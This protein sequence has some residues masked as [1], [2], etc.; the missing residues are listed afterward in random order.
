[1]KMLF[2]HSLRVIFL[3]KIELC[4]ALLIHD[5]SRSR[6]HCKDLTSH[7]IW[8]LYEAYDVKPD[9]IILSV[10]PQ[11]YQIDCFMVEVLMRYGIFKNSYE[12][13]VEAYL[14]YC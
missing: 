7:D 14:M 5:R 10:H 9:D 1:M 6:Y 4:L 2:Q 11:T 12:R 3:F 8:K 13:R